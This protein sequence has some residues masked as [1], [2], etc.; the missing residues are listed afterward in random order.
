VPWQP[1]SSST[2]GGGAS[3]GGGGGHATHSSGGGGTATKG[4][5]GHSKSESE[6]VGLYK[7]QVAWE[8]HPVAGPCLKSHTPM[9]QCASDRSVPGWAIGLEVGLGLVVVAAAVIVTAGGAAAVAAGAAG[10]V[11]AGEAALLGAGGSATV[12]AAEQTAEQAS[13]EIPAA[14]ELPGLPSS[15]P[16]PLGLGSTGRAA[17]A[18]LTEQLAM[19]QAMS[20][21]AAGTRVPFRM[22]DPRWPESDGWVKMAQNVN[23]VE[24]H[25]V[26]NP[27]AG[28]VDDFKFVGGP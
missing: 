23:G 7:H 8:E 18:N 17:P 15:A 11:G 6:I 10:S 16:E 4:G 14:A 5:K 13:A 20:N 2:G 21:P 24:I 22:T 26:R 1:T 3:G 12:L 9:T 28:L 27:V 25:Y 19:E